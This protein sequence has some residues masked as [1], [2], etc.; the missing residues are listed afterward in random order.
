M[1]IMIVEIIIYK[2]NQNLI[3]S[4]DYYDLE[5]IIYKINFG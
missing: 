1:I 4:N 3:K 2:I 5:I